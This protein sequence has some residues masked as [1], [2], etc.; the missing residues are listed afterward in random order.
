MKLKIVTI[1]LILLLIAPLKI[2]SQ[3]EITKEFAVIENKNLVIK[4]KPDLTSNKINYNKLN[5]GENCC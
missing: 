2:L 1:L 4:E 5:M 3:T